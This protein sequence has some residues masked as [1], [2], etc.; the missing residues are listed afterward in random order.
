MELE[1]VTTS[2]PGVEVQIEVVLV[3]VVELLDIVDAVVGEEVAG[4]EIEGEET[5]EVDTVAEDVVATEIVVEDT[6]EGEDVDAV[7]V[8]L[9]VETGEDSVVLLWSVGE[10]VVPVEGDNVDKDDLVLAVGVDTGV[11]SVEE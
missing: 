9:D 8:W 1:R 11:V 6:A 10:E 7:E 3:V 2:A 4:E 5:V